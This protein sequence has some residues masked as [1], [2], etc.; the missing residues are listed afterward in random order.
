MTREG[1]IYIPPVWVRVCFWGGMGGMPFEEGGQF[2]KQL[3]VGI[4]FQPRGF[5]DMLFQMNLKS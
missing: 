3:E 4:G 2:L 1:Y 5:Q